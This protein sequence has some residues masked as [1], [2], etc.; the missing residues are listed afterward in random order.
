MAITAVCKTM[1][2]I[3]ILIIGYT[4]Y[5]VYNTKYLYYISPIEELTQF[6]Y[7]ISTNSLA[8]YYIITV[9]YILLPLIY[10]ITIYIYTVVLLLYSVYTINTTT[11]NI[12]LN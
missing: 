8:I 7:Q 2:C 1:Y 6:I 11:F 5:T 9:D 12:L 10:T 4:I 3:S